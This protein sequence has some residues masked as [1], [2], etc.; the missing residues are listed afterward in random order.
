MCGRKA[1]SSVASVSKT[2]FQAA[3]PERQKPRYV[4][5][6]NL[7][8]FYVTDAMYSLISA[9]NQSPV[10]LSGTLCLQPSESRR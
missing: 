8:L 2:I 7:I 1:Q 3:E 5:W 4:L 10:Q 9:K 6:G